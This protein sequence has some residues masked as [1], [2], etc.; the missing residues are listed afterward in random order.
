MSQELKD[1]RGKITV[2]TDCVLDAESRI[3]GKDKSELV[4]GIL[5]EWAAQRV[6]VARLIDK[7]LQSEG[8][9]GIAER[10]SGNSREGKR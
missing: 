1:F 8:E 3:T 5:A 2:E 9:P 10:R 4:R 7:N 6:H